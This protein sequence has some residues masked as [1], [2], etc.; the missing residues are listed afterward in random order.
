LNAMARRAERPRRSV[1]TLLGRLAA[2][3]S[4]VLRPVWPQRLRSQLALVLA[5]YLLAAGGVFVSL[6]GT[7][8]YPKS[9]IV[10]FY[11]YGLFAVTLGAAVA[12]TL[13]RTPLAVTW[14]FGAF[15]FSAVLIYLRFGAPDA[16]FTQ[17]LTMALFITLMTVSAPR[18]ENGSHPR[19]GPFAVTLDV[20]IGVAVG[21]AVTAL[22]LAVTAAPFDESVG[23]YLSQAAPSQG[24]AR[25]NVNAILSDIRA[26][27]S[28]AK[29][30][31]VLV[32][33]IAALL[34]LKRS[35]ALAVRVKQEIVP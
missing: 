6:D 8:P 35:T 23:T 17:L 18:L 24:H 14:A 3:I 28:L 19:R 12:L 26:F 15:S 21:G 16:A 20:L 10:D 4:V 2:G 22:L 33:G 30:A 11:A 5:A 25:T 31:A 34:V 9:I 27:D 32:A 13:A 29:I 1:I 7:V